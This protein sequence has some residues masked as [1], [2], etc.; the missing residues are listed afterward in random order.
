MDG[1][2]GVRSRLESCF[3]LDLPEREL[4][5]DFC[6]GFTPLLLNCLVDGDFD[7]FFESFIKTFFSF[8]GGETGS[9]AL[10]SLTYGLLLYFGEGGT[11]LAFPSVPD[12]II[13]DLSPWSFFGGPY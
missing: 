9:Y 8:V 4:R 11:T 7:A 2:R 6:V 5:G 10:K 1:V 3:L 13:V 12:A